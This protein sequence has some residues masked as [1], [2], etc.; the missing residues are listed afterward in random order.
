MNT[1]TRRKPRIIR[2]PLTERQKLS[3]VRQLRA[4]ERE[5]HTIKDSIAAD[6]RLIATKDEIQ[7]SACAMICGIRKTLEGRWPKEPAQ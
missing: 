1:T 3:L 4:L 5:Y 6:G 7:K 2:R